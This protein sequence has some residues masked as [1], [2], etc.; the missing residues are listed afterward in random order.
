MLELR[1]AKFLRVFLAG[2]KLHEAIIARCR[3]LQVAGATVL[4]AQEGFG[5][6]PDIHR[7]RLLSNDRPLVIHIVDS[8]EKIARLIPE[9]ERMIGT[10][11]LAVS[12]VQLLRIHKDNWFTH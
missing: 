7:A 11:M 5:G 2:G 6:G 3:E 9:I 8:E 12:D 4:A 1:P 10:G